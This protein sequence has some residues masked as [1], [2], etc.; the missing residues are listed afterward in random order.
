MKCLSEVFK[1]KHKKSFSKAKM[2]PSLY[3][4]HFVWT[5]L[6]VPN[7]FKLWTSCRQE[8]PQNLAK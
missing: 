6:V 5:P 4:W 2:L 3:A 7:I 1:S 8:N